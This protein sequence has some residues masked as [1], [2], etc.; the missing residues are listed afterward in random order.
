MREEGEEEGEGAVSTGDTH[1]YNNI[2]NTSSHKNYTLN[3]KLFFFSRARHTLRLF[4]AL[5]VF[6]IFDETKATQKHAHS[7]T[8]AIYSLLLHFYGIFKL[9]LNV[10]GMRYVR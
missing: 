2:H 9:R 7:Q 1:T 3:N 6:V 4:Y 8:T 10:V 5:W